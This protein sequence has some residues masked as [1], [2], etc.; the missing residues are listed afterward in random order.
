MPVDKIHEFYKQ[1]INL[2]SKTKRSYDIW[3]GL[4]YG[5]GVAEG[6]MDGG[7]G[8]YVGLAV[9]VEGVCG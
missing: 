2:A 5:G 8:D 3:V 1:A 9:F 7:S 4:Q 6:A